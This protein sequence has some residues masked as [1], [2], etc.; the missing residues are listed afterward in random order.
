MSKLPVSLYRDA[1]FCFFVLLFS[2]FVIIP[3]F[4]KGYFPTHDGEWAVVRLSDMYREVKDMQI[5]PRISGN[6]NFGYGYPLFNFAYP[7]PYYT[8]LILIALGVGLVN[9]IK[10][11][12]GLSVIASSI[13]MYFLASRLWVDRHSGVVSSLLYIYLPKR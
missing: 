9:S 8:G 4:Q 1:F 3:F 2:L 7:F 12:F 5:P 13:I 11:L 10:I 6:L